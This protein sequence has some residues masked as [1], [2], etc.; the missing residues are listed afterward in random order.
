VDFEE[1]SLTAEELDLARRIEAEKY[2]TDDWTGRVS[3]AV[4]L[5]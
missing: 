4:Q 5:A 1:Q 3:R 2:G